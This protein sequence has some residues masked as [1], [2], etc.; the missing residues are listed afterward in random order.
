MIVLI[1]GIYSLL[2]NPLLLIAIGFLVGVSLR[3]NPPFPPDPSSSA[4]P[5]RSLAVC[6]HPC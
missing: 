5:R 1:L 6:E 4:L 2:T 3:A